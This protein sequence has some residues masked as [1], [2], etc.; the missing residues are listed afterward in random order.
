MCEQYATDNY[1]QENQ[2]SSSRMTR[3]DWSR[4]EKIRYEPSVK[5][6]MKARCEEQ[7]HE[8]ENRCSQMF[9]IYQGCKWCDDSR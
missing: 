1:R 4:F 8:W 9:R 2:T 7:G 5:L 3:E 6:A